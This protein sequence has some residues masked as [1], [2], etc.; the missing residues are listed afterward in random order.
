MP[1]CREPSRV[2]GLPNA[3]NVAAACVVAFFD[4]MDPTFCMLEWIEAGWRDPM[5]VNAM[6]RICRTRALSEA[7]MFLEDAPAQQLE[8]LHQLAIGAP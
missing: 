2:A 3:R 5:L 6:L 1:A 7:C 4:E 8:L